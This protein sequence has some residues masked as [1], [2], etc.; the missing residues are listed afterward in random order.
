[1]CFCK[2]YWKLTIAAMGAAFV[3]CGVCLRIKPLEAE[4]HSNWTREKKRAK[5]DMRTWT[6]MEYY[7]SSRKLH[8][9]IVI[10]LPP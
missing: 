5:L 3:D 2:T 8:D 6:L 9:V 10:T 1:M 4:L 7:V